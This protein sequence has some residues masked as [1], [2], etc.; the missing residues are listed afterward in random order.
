MGW[1]SS[2]GL[3][4]GISH[5]YEW[6]KKNWTVS[7]RWMEQNEPPN[8]QT[9]LPVYKLSIQYQLSNNG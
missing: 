3:C 5:T 8:L 9:D 4:E 7:E 1:K 2:I 6:F